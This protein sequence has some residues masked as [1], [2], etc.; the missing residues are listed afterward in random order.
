MNETQK[1]R[2]QVSEGCQNCT[3]YCNGECYKLYGGVSVRCDCEGPYDGLLVEKDFCCIFYEPNAS[4]EWAAVADTLED[5]VRC[6]NCGGS[7]V[8]SFNPNLNPN[9]FPGTAT[10][11]CTR[12]GGTGIEDTANASREA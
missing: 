10:A 4:L 2:I 5:I 9:R 8:I 7:G 6:E 11:K 12:C 3:H 1:V